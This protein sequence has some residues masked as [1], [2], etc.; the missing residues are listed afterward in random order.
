[1]HSSPRQAAGDSAKGLLKGLLNHT[2][3]TRLDGV[4]AKKRK[5]LL[6]RLKDLIE[7]VVELAHDGVR[8]NNVPKSKNINPKLIHSV[9]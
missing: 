1:M 5:R 2:S 7:I 4:L 3:G 6:C 8:K 9:S